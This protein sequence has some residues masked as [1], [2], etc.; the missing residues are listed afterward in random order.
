[1]GEKE[2]R[3]INNALKTQ[4]SS[5]LPLPELAAIVGITYQPA[6]RM[7]IRKVPNRLLCSCA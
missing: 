3:I 1:M 7:K 4:P 5:S 6:N 2:V